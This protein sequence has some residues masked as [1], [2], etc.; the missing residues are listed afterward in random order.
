MALLATGVAAVH[1][2]GPNPLGV[3]LLGSGAWAL[4][5]WALL[6]PVKELQTWIHRHKDLYILHHASQQTKQSLR[7]RTPGER[8]ARLLRAM[9]R[10][11]R[12]AWKVSAA[13]GVV[14]VLAS[15]V[16]TYGVVTGKRPGRFDAA[17]EAFEV[18]WNAG[19]AEGIRPLFDPRVREAEGTWLGA[20][21]SGHGWGDG[22]PALPEGTLREGEGERYVDYELEEFPLTA[23]FVLNDLEW[24]L[25]R[26]ELPY[27]SIQPALARFRS[28]WDGGATET[29]AAFF[30]PERRD[31]VLEQLD[32]TRT[33][34]GWDAFP[35]VLETTLQGEGD[36]RVSVVMNVG[37]RQDLR[38]AWFF[39]D[40][41]TWGVVGLTMPTIWHRRDDGGGE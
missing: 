15:A 38:T 20:V 21:I 40:D 25:A 16:G 23:R 1:A 7:G 9:Q 6:F 28:A 18:A 31:E 26:V 5:S 2:L 37:K 32:A 24:W 12:R 22:L 30:A 35:P 34:R 33:R 17:L 13:A 29:L 36:R 19:D 8:H 11:D 10:A 41:G 14:L 3:G 27:P 39:H 4:L